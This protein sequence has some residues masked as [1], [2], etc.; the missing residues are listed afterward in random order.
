M[1]Q[2]QLT[3]AQCREHR[4]NAHHL[5]PVVSI[6]ND[7]LT[8]TV[9]K[10]IDTALNSHGLIKIRVFND[11]RKEREAILAKLADVLNAAAVQHI[12]KALVLWRPKLEKVR[13]VEE[14]RM[15]A[16]R[17]YKIVKPNKMPGRKPEIKRINVMGNQRLTISGN[18][19]RA[20]PKVKSSVKKRGGR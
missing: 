8:S 14:D 18:V 9:Q 5:S 17:E 19:K 2:I 12:G 4:A 15:P 10:E 16:P 7:G 11:D 3:S 20:R 1:S 6:G 13:A